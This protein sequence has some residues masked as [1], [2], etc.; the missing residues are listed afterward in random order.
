MPRLSDR[1]LLVT[2]KIIPLGNKIIP[3]PFPHT[4]HL[5]VLD[6]AN[7]PAQASSECCEQYHLGVQVQ[8][9][10]RSA[11]F[12]RDTGACWLY[13]L[14]F[15]IF[16][17]FSF[18]YR[19]FPLQGNLL[20][21]SCPLHLGWEQGRAGVGVGPSLPFTSLHH[22]PLF[23]D[24]CSFLFM[25]VCALILQRFSSS[26][27]CSSPWAL[28]TAHLPHSGLLSSIKGFPLSCQVFHCLHDS[29]TLASSGFLPWLL[30]LILFHCPLRTLMTVLLSDTFP[31]P[32]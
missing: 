5:S 1:H 19:P 13:F 26:S 25:V 31:S 21:Q 3:I 14:C 17:L 28:I 15:L 32:K 30:V 11:T 7:L 16:L 29:K 10:L 4:A 22:S 27:G 24:L 8:F 2:K 12:P 20:A 18:T 6:G 23:S 9:S